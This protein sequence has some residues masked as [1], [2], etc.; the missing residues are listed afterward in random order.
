V[1]SLPELAELLG[2]RFRLLS[3]GSRTGRPQHRSLRACVEWSHD[4]ISPDEQAL[5]E[6]LAV[7]PGTF[8]LPAVAALGAVEPGMV[9][10]LIHRLATKSLLAVEHRAGGTRYRMLDT[11]RQFAAEFLAADPTARTAY[12]RRHAEYFRRRGEELNVALRGPG[13]DRVLDRLSADHDNMRAAMSWLT[14]EGAD[15]AGAVRLAGAL[16][17]F[18]YLRGDYREG[19]GW[20]TAAL[21]M[22]D[23]AAVPAGARA[24]AIEG[25]AA[26]AAYEC[27]YDA[28]TALAGHS[29]TLYTELADRRGMARALT[30]LGS[31]S[32]ERGAYEQ[33]RKLHR[34]A[35]TLF[36]EVGD[37][38]GVGHSMQLLGFACWLSGDLGAAHDWSTRALSALTAVGDKERIA[39]TLLDLGAVALYQND[40]RAATAHCEG[41]LRLFQEVGFQ[42]GIAWA[43]QLLGLADVHTG[44]LPRALDRLAISATL[45]SRLGDRWRL[46]SVLEVLAYAATVLD[47]PAVCADLLARADSA[48]QAIGA[49]TPAC[50]RPLVV[51]TR[52]WVQSRLG[53][54][55]PQT[56]SASAVLLDDHIAA[57]RTRAASGGG[58][59]S[60]AS[61]T[62]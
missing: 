3:A 19:R 15:P 28:A 9:L 11:I 30:R 52:H 26:L 43:E 45:H 44:D 59:A 2:D 20:L 33:A 21:G 54:E 4:L 47:S 12:R 57:L 56:T 39:W 22:A 7:F 17:Q 42:E 32:R 38:W 46:A 31:V 24:E 34:R 5:F 8:D 29:L 61:P 58:A 13:L 1:L 36:D 35:M 50:E 40:H 10:D 37:D 55:P 49:P 16:W 48:R 41:A 18:C 60:M 51:R 25:A 27:D 62:R 23:A 53:A 6:A 14:G